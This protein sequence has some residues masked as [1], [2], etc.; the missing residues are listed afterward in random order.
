MEFIPLEFFDN[1]LH[2]YVISAVDDSEVEGKMIYIEETRRL[3]DDEI[4]E[5]TN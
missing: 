1:L 3:Q 4:Q 2:L 5:Q